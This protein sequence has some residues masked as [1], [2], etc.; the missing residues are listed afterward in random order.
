MKHHVVI[1]YHSFNDPI[2]KGLMLKYLLKFQ[3]AERGHLFHVI[4]FEQQSYRM[5]PE[6][7]LSVKQALHD[8][9]GI[10]WVPLHYHTGGTFLLFKK[11]WDVISVIA[12]VYSIKQKT[13]LKTIIGFTTLSGAISFLIA[14]LLKV[15]L[16]LL[17][18]EPHS[19]YMA[20]FGT[21]SR[22][23]LS[24]RLLNY[25]EKK[26]VQYASYV[27]VPTQNGF[28]RLSKELGLKET[29]YFVPTCIDVDDFSFKPESRDRIRAAIGAEDN[30]TVMIYLGKFGGIYFSVEQVAETFK[31]LSENNENL[32]FYV[33]T[34]DNVNEINDEFDRMEL[35]GKYYVRGRIAYEAISDH[36]SSADIG[37]LFI[38]PYPS[39]LYR[40]PIKTANYL[41]CGLPYFITQGI[42]D[43]S[44]AATE[45][46]VGIVLNEGEKTDLTGQL[47]RIERD[48][49]KLREK[50][51]ELRGINY[52]V[53]FLKRGLG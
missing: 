28:E 10:R 25:L 21:W 35:T 47:T 20:D 50:A 13:A 22:S 2:F 6:E 31:M 5:T 11:L 40:C 42:G 44:R 45:L 32:L 52:A 36:L 4:T 1:I 8:E 18:I 9:H 15:P 23:G 53:E 39:Q 14:K 19:E 37:V 29:L 46:N 43:D 12:K 48:R 41:A 17:N 51:K 7:M 3:Q 34:T 26:Q 30:T 38:P 27:A 33:I 16:V 24:Y 49:D